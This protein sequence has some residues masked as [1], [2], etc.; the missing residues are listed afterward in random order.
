MPFQGQLHQAVEEPFV[1]KAAGSPEFRVDAGGGEAGDGIDL[2][3]QQPVRSAFQEEVDARHARGVYGLEGRA[4]YAPYLLHG[5]VRYGGGGDELHP[6]LYVLRLVVVED[7]LLDDDLSGNGDL[8]VF[9]AEDGD[10]YLSGVDALLDDDAPVV[11]CG[12]INGFAKFFGVLRFADADARAEVG[13]LDEARVSERTFYLPCQALPVLLPLVTGKGDP[14]DLREAV[15]G[16]DL[17]HG[18]LVHAGGASEHS[19]PDVGDAGEFEHALYGAV[20]AIR[21]VQ[22]GEDHI[23]GSETHREFLGR[24]GRGAG[25][26][27]A[28]A[29]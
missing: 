13:G 27:E 19:A 7:V 10:L 6:A 28:R 2:V 14:L 3:Q 5:L 18:R 21:A 1:R 20:F 11:A 29:V 26:F 4:G 22:D 24:G 8:G 17:L 9:V 16:E 25:D 23:Y 12:P 15:V